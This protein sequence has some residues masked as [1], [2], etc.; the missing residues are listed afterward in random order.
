MSA[1]EKLTDER[2]RMFKLPTP[3]YTAFAPACIADINDSKE[4]AGDMI[5][6]EDILTMVFK[7]QWF[8]NANV[9]KNLIPRVF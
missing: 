9:R 8:D 4:P 1:R 6:I 7:Q 3:K 5:S 2:A